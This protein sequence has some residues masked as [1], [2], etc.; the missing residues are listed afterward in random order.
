ME[1]F[2]ALSEE[3]P[4]RLGEL[5]RFL[6]QDGGGFPLTDK[7]LE[8]GVA[9]GLACRPCPDGAPTNPAGA[10]QALEESDYIIGMAIR[11][12]Y[13]SPLQ[14]SHILSKGQTLLA[15]LKKEGW[16]DEEGDSQ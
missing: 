3:Y 1:D 4:L 14:G 16:K 2:R 8:C 10:I 11:A 5:V 6:R 15:L 13:L 9:A 7:L 12:G